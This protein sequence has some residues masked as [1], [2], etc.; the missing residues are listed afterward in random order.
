MELLQSV[1]LGL[2]I[3]FFGFVLQT[4][5]GGVNRKIVARLQKR[6]GPKW[7]QEFIDIFKY[8]KYEGDFTSFQKLIY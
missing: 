2:G 6:R 3:A 5:L 7:Y 1:L 4:S 8:S